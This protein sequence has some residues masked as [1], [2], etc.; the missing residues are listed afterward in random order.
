MSIYDKYKTVIGL[1]IHAQ[2]STKSKAYTSDSAEFGS[3][4]NTNISPI[5]LGHPGTLPRLNENNID[6][7]SLQ[8]NS[9]I[10]ENVEIDKLLQLFDTP[11]SNKSSDS[12]QNLEK[13]EVK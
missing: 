8:Q 12:E 13:T 5:S 2:L 11:N 10:E 7:T 3:S 1:E 4:P 9:I 6:S